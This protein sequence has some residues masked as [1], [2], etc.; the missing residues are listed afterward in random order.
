[1]ARAAG[2]GHGAGQDPSLTAAPRACLADDGLVRLV[3]P[4]AQPS[5]S[6]R[7]VEPSSVVTIGAFDGVHVGHRA[8]IAELRRLATERGCIT[9]VVTFDP[10]PAAVVRPD[11]APLLLTDLEQKLALLAAC[12]VDRTVVIRFDAARAAQSAGDFVREVLVDGLGATAVAVG[13]DF[14]FGRGR[15]GT[16]PFLQGLGAEHGFD[17][18]GLRLTADGG[19]PVSS[20]RIRKLLLDGEVGAA[21][22]LLGRDHEVRGIVGHG[23]ARGREWGFPTANVAVP[24]DILLPADGVYAGRYVHPDGTSTPAAISLG[25]RPQVYEDRGQRLLEPHLLGPAGAAWDGDLYDQPARVQ[26]SHHIRGQATFPT[27][28]EL[29]AQIGRDCTEARRLLSAT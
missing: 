19:E 13:H 25:R 28:D 2:C 5:P 3:R 11:S 10:H 7:A 18:L 29:L 6:L 1:M 24:G 8:V 9:A 20:T 27:V 26:F 14:H 16:V 22:V 17:V 21:A 23:D 4:S 12:G 15:E